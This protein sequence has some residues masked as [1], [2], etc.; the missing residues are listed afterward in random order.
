MQGAGLFRLKRGKIMP[1]SLQSK[2]FTNM[3]VWYY[4]DDIDSK[5]LFCNS[6]GEWF[7]LT[8]EPISI[9]P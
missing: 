3:L 8:F 9:E 4:P 1:T 2:S 5:L 6:D 7:N